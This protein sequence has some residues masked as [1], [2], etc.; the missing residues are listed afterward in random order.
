MI[1]KQ[2]PALLKMN[3]ITHTIPIQ[4]KEMQYTSEVT[5]NNR[6]FDGEMPLTDVRENLQTREAG[7]RLLNQLHTGHEGSRTNINLTDRPYTNKGDEGK[8]PVENNTT[9]EDATVEMCIQ[10]VLETRSLNETDS[11]SS[12]LS[13]IS[14][15]NE[16]HETSDFNEH[17]Y[18]ENDVIKQY[19]TSNTI[20]HKKSDQNF[21]TSVMAT[22]RVPISLDTSCPLR[23]SGRSLRTIT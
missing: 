8:I 17:M 11:Q 2:L 4:G 20:M 1:K 7:G 16:M 12:I 9:E 23:K 5:G 13:E 14:S 15:F 6:T 18:S 21:D 3:S 19:H 10:R 22:E